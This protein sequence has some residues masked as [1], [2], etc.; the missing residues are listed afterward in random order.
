MVALGGYEEDIGAV[1][2]PGTGSHDLGSSL[3]F[4][5]ADVE[6]D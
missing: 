6:G 3:D 4:A 5:I 1:G 2:F